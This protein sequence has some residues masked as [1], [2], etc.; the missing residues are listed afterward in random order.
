MVACSTNS[1]MLMLIQFESINV[2][3]DIERLVFIMK[4][5][6]FCFPWIYFTSIISHCSYNWYKIITFTTHCFS[7]IVHN[8]LRH[9]YKNLASIHKIS[10]ISAPNIFPS[11]AFMITLMLNLC[12]I[13]YNS[14]A[15]ILHITRLYLIKDPCIIFALLVASAR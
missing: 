2:F 6:G 11:L 15:K 14:A 13:P 5:F 3:K 9:L 12:A 1:V 7:C 4:A 8:F 10:R